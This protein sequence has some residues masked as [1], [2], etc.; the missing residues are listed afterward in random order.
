VEKYQVAKY[1]KLNHRV[2]KAEWNP[3]S[4]KWD[5]QIHNTV[6]DQL[7]TDTAD[8]VLS[9]TGALSRWR[10]P[11]IAGLH[12]YR[13]LLMHS[14]A[15]NSDL[16]IGEIEGESEKWRDQTVAVIGVGSSAVQIVPSLQKVC[17]KVVNYVR[18]KTCELTSCIRNSMVSF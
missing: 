17:G 8:F 13:G 11:D 2:I 7:V 4:G 5:L 15:Y 10:W 18:G 12:D 16:G 9:T 6:S 1:I 14:A 3:S